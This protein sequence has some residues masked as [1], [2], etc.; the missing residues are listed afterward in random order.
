MRIL[1]RIFATALLA[2]AAC[3]PTE[4]DARYTREPGVLM[5][6]ALDTYVEVPAAAQAGQPFTVRT[7]SWG[8]T[9]RRPT[10]A[11]LTQSGLQADV[12]IFVL[13]PVDGV[14]NRALGRLEHE[15]Q[16][17]FPQAGTGVVRIHGQGFDVEGRP[18]P[19]TLERT[20]TVQ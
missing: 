14:C 15:V 19:I 5:G 8:S 9:C 7:A 6:P 18:V 11:E 12:R 10:P 16:L 3:S 2:A 13:Q 1:P 4:P 20:V 17:A